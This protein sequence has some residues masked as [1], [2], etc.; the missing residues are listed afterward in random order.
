MDNFLRETEESVR[1]WAMNASPATLHNALDAYR[2]AIVARMQAEID[3]AW[4][5]A[6]KAEERCTALSE[7]A[8]YWERRSR[9]A[10]EKLREIVVAWD[11]QQ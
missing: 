7:R 1:E 8:F 9:D 11:S 2:T 4:D 3:E 6:K 10:E 5:T